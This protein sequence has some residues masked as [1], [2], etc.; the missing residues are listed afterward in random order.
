MQKA[1]DAQNAFAKSQDALNSELDG[2]A[3]DLG[4]T[5]D[6]V[7]DMI[8][9]VSALNLDDENVHPVN[10]VG[11][12]ADTIAQAEKFAVYTL[13]YDRGEGNGEETIA[14]YGVQEGSRY[15]TDMDLGSGKVVFGGGLVDKFGF[16]QGDAIDLYDKYE[17]KTHTL[18]F[19]GDEGTWG[20]KSTMNHLYEPGRFQCDVRQRCGLFQ[21]IR[22][23]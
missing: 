8:D 20:T 13:Q 18:T 6:D 10:T 19:T 16:K 2:V 23:R 9:K 3:V 21:W 1:Q 12:G 22:L 4:A 11:N 7:V 14:A 17:D 15:W 5:R